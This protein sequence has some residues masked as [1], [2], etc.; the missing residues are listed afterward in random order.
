ME[1]SEDQLI[2]RRYMR[3]AEFIRSCWEDG[4]GI[5]TRIFD[6]VNLVNN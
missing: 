1:F 6:Y 5:H 4:S 2:K 3:V